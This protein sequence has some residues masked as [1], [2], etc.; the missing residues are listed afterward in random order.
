MVDLTAVLFNTLEVR[1][2][3]ML[4]RDVLLLLSLTVK[5]FFFVGNK[6]RSIDEISIVVG[7]L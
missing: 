4:Q 1:L 7:W 2:C 6:A 3:Y 5:A